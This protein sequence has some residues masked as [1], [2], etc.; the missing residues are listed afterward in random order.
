MTRRV[1]VFYSF[2][3]PYCYLLTNRLTALAQDFD[4][5]VMIRP[6]YPIAVRDAEFF[7]RV[8]SLYRPYHMQ[9]SSRLAE[10]LNIYYRR[11]V[12][13]PIVQDLE[14]GAIAAERGANLLLI[15]RSQE[16]L[17]AA[18]EECRQRGATVEVLA[19]DPGELPGLAAIGGARHSGFGSVPAYLRIDR[20]DPADGG[21]HPGVF[22]GPGGIRACDS[23]TKKEVGEHGRQ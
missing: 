16:R 18:A 3:S 11:P 20:A 17:E 5:A 21:G 22:D 6:V 2:R 10:Y 8:D 12:P 9:N 13:Y 7:R 1:D 23:E 4:V 19:A 15:A 14:S